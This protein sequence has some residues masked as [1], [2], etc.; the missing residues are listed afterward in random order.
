MGAEER[1]VLRACRSAF[2]GVSVGDAVVADAGRTIDLAQRLGVLGLV[3]SHV[4]TTP[5]AD[6]RWDRAWLANLTRNL[7]A[8]NELE[9]WRDVLRAKGI[10][11]V[12]FKGPALAVRAF[13]G[14]HRRDWG[15]LDLI[16]APS[17]FTRA[18]ATLAENGAEPMWVGPPP[19]H[20]WVQGRGV[21]FTVPARAGRLLLDLHAGWRPLWG[22]L[23]GGELSDAGLVDVDI[24]GVQFRTLDAELAAIHAA[25]HFVQHGYSL[26]T[27]V[28]VIAAFA[29][30]Q[31][32]GRLDALRERARSM[33]LS[34][35]LDAARIAAEQFLEN[36]RAPSLRSDLGTAAALTDPARLQRIDVRTWL[37]TRRAIGH[38][39]LFR[40]AVRTV[41]L[42]RGYVSMSPEWIDAHH[43][44]LRR[45]TRAVRLA[46]RT[47]PVTFGA[48][49]RMLCRRVAER[50]GASPRPVLADRVLATVVGA[51]GGIAAGL[52]LTTGN[53]AAA[54]GLLVLVAAVLHVV[55]LIAPPGERGDLAR[56]AVVALLVRAA[57][58][59][60]LYAAALAEGKGGFITGD[61]GGYSRLAWG[62]AQWLHG[63]PVWPHIPPGWGGDAHLLG[64]FVY[65][66]SAIY[67]VVGLQPL[68]VEFLNAALVTVAIVIG[69]DIAHRVFGTRAAVLVTAVLALDPANVLFS[70]LL[71]KDSVS[72]L[73]VTA[74]LW[75]VIRFQ[76]RPAFDRIAGA[77]VGIALMYSIRSYLSFVLLGAVV[78]GT[79]LAPR[80]GRW[81]RLTW[82][83][84]AAIACGGAL[85]VGLLVGRSD[86]PAFSP[87]SFEQ[88]RNAM[89]QG[90]NTAFSID[91]S[92][93]T[94]G[95]PSGGGPPEPPPDQP[96]VAPVTLEHTPVP[97]IANGLRGLVAFLFIAWVVSRSARR[98]VIPLA[99]LGAVGAVVMW[100]TLKG[101]GTSGGESD[102]V[103][104]NQT[105]AYLPRGLSNVFLT[106]Y[107]WVVRRALDLP[108]I[109]EML[110]WYAIL[111]AA[112][113]TVARRPRLGAASVTVLAFA[114]AMFLV[115]FLTE[116]NVGTVF[117]H[118]AMTVAPFVTLLAAPTLLRLWD[119]L[120]RRAASRRLLGSV[121]AKPPRQSL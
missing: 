115:F 106:P 47:A 79:A 20:D 117:R 100:F 83:A 36:G 31:A 29:R 25:C 46:T 60:V 116:G 110:G 121:A 15:D 114:G 78:L 18:Y 54:V 16:V 8:V 74:V 102:V 11:I 92:P 4:R 111:G 55:R 10:E 52:A 84:S 120:R 98:P 112:L 105:I 56:L 63:T 1:A 7:A 35:T 67:F 22:A 91:A 71:L 40:D 70:A 72:L 109:P 88:V 41:W 119:A 5:G 24:G 69:W 104:L 19:P 39:A 68:L 86:V 28:D 113:W 59:A 101:I 61:D 6:V 33:R 99:A 32:E 75:S 12:V 118:R 107:P 43:V 97:A 51:T 17:A 49:I 23:P 94:S 87:A 30:V 85:T 44:R 96:I 58:A 108:T 82:S 73:V 93:P 77:A 103:A 64:T 2:A 34:R 26:K 62:Y 37:E 80:T 81:M 13:G 9:H 14:L 38:R 95:A 53:P 21:T 3:S 48:S 89:A 27:L 90:A 45:L 50:T 65:L 57:A 42:P 76:E 66:T